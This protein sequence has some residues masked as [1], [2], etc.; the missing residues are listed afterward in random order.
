MKPV[1]TTYCYGS[2]RSPRE[3][4]RIGVA[5]FAPRGIRHEDWQRCGYFDLW[6]PLLAPDPG[7]VVKYRQQKITYANFARH[8]RSGIKRKESRQVIDLIAGI[9]LFLP[10]SLGC[11]CKDGAKCHRSVLKQLIANA[12]EEKRAGFALVAKPGWE[13]DRMRFSSPVCFADFE[14]SPRRPLRNTK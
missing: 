7:L 12:S 10:V 9:A 8:Y 13:I 2:E 6:V 1:I 11:F 3:G 4:L 14:E 5:R